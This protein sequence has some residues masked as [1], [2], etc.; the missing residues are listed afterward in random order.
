MGGKRD[1]IRLFINVKHGNVDAAQENM[2]PQTLARY[3]IG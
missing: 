2:E 3:A 1:F